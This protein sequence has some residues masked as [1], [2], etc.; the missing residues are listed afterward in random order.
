M[1]LNRNRTG[2]NFLSSEITNIRNRDMIKE[3]ETLRNLE[4]E[5]NRTNVRFVNLQEVL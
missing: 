4:A 3:G 2:E 5:G 1:E